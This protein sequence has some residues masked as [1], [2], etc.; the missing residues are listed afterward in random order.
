MLDL[1]SPAASGLFL[2]LSAG[3]SPGPLLTLMLSET[4]RHG[5]RAGIM[6]AVAPLCTD[7]P[8][9]LLA[10]LLHRLLP[11]HGWLEA[12]LGLTGGG[13]LLWLG[14]KGLRPGAHPPAETSHSGRPAVEAPSLGKA[15][16]AN[17]LNPN[18][19]IFWLTIGVPAM[20][21]LS[22]RSVSAAGLF[23]LSFY[24]LLVGSKAVVAALTARSASFLAGRSYVLTL[25]ALSLGLCAY[26]LIFIYRALHFI[27]GA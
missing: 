23:V 2:G 25:M 7:L 19:Y 11:D 5:L 3:L 13:Y 21:A 6:V 24:A 1:T 15:I 26:G 17:L 10:L 9:I 22:Q 8:I 4:L 14:V 16:I 27:T 12:L 20:L 18:P